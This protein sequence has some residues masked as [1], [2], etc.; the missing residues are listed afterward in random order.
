MKKFHIGDVL[1][2]TTGKMLSPEGI[3]G[4][5]T[6]L[7]YITKSN[8]YNSELIYI[9]EECRPYLLQQFPELKEETAIDVTPQNWKTYLLTMIEKYGEYLNVKSIQEHK[10]QNKLNKTAKNT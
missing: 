1:S 6:I 4:V 3:D 9:I 10:Q 2:I 8:L 7:N 5:L